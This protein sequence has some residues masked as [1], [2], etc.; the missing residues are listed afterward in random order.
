MYP[1]LLLSAALIAP[2]APLPR[3]A[4][5]TQT[6]PAPLVLSL[7]ADS[8]GAVRIVGNVPT[9]VTV[10]NTYVTLEQVVV[11]GKPVQRQVQKQVDQD[12]VTQQYFNKTLA[13]CKGTFA[14]ADGKPLTVNEA[15]NRV[16][17]G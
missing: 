13:D 15:T 4:A 17:A 2:A 16:K 8:A 3:D 1:S 11:D 5:P 7:K 10:T 14:T 9:K 12:I 6:G